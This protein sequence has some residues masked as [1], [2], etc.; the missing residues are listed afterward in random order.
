M[1]STFRKCTRHM[2]FFQ[3]ASRGRHLPE[4]QGRLWLPIKHIWRK[5]LI[6]RINK[7]TSHILISVN[8]WIMFMEIMETDTAPK[9]KLVTEISHRPDFTVTDRNQFCSIDMNGKS[10]NCLDH[11]CP[12]CLAVELKVSKF[13]LVGLLIRTN[14]NK[15]QDWKE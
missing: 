11:R 15:W 7:K 14:K 2:L 12:S 6:S 4:Q 9:L 10:K 5:E 13:S 8:Q 1:S 3:Q